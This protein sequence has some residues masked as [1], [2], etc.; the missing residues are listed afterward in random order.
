M[1]TRLFFERESSKNMCLKEN[2]LTIYEGMTM[3]LSTSDVSR[4]HAIT[5]EMSNAI[6]KF[7]S[8]KTPSLEKNVTT[9]CGRKYSVA[10]V[11]KINGEWKAIA[12]VPKGMFV[13]NNCPP[14]KRL[15][16]GSTFFKISH[17]SKSLITNIATMHL[18]EDHADKVPANELDEYASVFLN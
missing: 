10:M 13:C 14:E 11:Y 18:F 1:L 8:D 3:T 6:N 16:I 5:Q 7:C 2:I 12:E 9:M 4:V 17:D 15:Q